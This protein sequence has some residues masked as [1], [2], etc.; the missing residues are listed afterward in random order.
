MIVV[1]IDPSLTSTG[2]AV[3]D[4]GKLK[5][6][7]TI[8]TKT[9]DGENE[10]RINTILYKIVQII[11]KECADYIVIERPAFLMNNSIRVVQDLAGLYY[12]ILC[13]LRRLGY[14]VV[15]VM[16]AEWKKKLQV[17]GR[18]RQEQKQSSISKVKELY[19]VNVKSNDESDAICI[20]TFGNMLDVETTN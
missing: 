13:K 2:Y 9:G 17:K 3:L 1:G 19:N 10:D 12:V 4:N 6:Y 8:K 18:N 15:P 16:P 20:A 14:L 7:G 5:D 11:T